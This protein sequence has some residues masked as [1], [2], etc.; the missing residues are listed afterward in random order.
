MS[1][2]CTPLFNLL[3]IIV[4]FGSTFQIARAQTSP[5]QP[6][7]AEPSLTGSWRIVL[8]LGGIQKDIIF[9]SKPRGFGSFLFMYSST[10]KSPIN[11]LAAVW[12]RNGNNRVSFSGEAELPLGTCCTEWG[13]VAFKGRF[14]SNDSIAGKVVF[15]TGIDEEE[16]PYKLRSVI[17]TFTAKRIVNR[18]RTRFKS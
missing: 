8:M 3:V 12:S 17:G 9:K 18:Q 15:V 13:T 4:V 7:P 16:S 2:L 11:S 14:E 5:A 10:D 6:A 1:K